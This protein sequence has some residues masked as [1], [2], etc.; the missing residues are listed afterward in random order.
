MGFFVSAVPFCVS[1]LAITPVIFDTL[2]LGG[3]VS[4]LLPTRFNS[5]VT[6][7]LIWTKIMDKRH[8]IS[9]QAEFKLPVAQSS[10]VATASR[11]SCLF[12]DHC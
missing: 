5:I 11:T 10:K 6:L 3:V 1:P 12:G 4:V 2:Q 7:V 9:L 8:W